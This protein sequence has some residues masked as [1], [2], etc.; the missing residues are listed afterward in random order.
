M[1]EVTALADSGRYTGQLDAEVDRLH[2]RFEGD[3]YT[4][5]MAL[6]DSFHILPPEA[7]AAVVR[8]VAGRKED[9]CG[10][11]A[12]NWLLD[13]SADVRLAAAST[14]HARV[15]RGIID[16]AFVAL[17]PPVASWIPPDDAYLVLHA[18][19]RDLGQ[20]GPFSPLKHPAC[21]PS[22]VLA[23][24]PEDGIGHG[25][26]AVLESRG[27]LALAVLTTE[28]GRGMADAFILKDEKARAFLSE[29]ESDADTLQLSWEAFEPVL[30]FAVADGL[31][32]GRPPPAGM[33]DVAL[34]C[35]LGDLRPRPMAA[36]DWLTLVDP[37]GELSGLPVR[38][39]ERLVERSG[40]WPDNHALVGTWIEGTSLIEHALNDAPGPPGE[41]APAFWAR[42]EE[43]REHWAI[44]MLISAHLLK[45]AGHGDWR[46]FAATASALLEG[47]ALGTIP[48]MRHV[49]H[50]TLDAWLAEEDLL[51][52]HGC[53][54]SG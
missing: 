6:N 50:A 46:S 29:R 5:H 32:A 39:R 37:A 16:A 2:R 24:L 41:S 51:C 35:D 7:R 3:I 47:R 54:A 28:I 23:L 20:R 44:S 34:D 33:I 19:S 1:P 42:L 48:I 4:V 26:V 38:D 36:R 53:P 21:R 31:A 45:G 30:A 11:L 8:S 40:A 27:S 14:L 18:A 49:F 9:Y 22:R 15:Q 17:M 13:A 43:R 52:T 25:F 12:L 10:R